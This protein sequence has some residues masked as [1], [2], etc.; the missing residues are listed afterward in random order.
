MSCW[1]NDEGQWNHRHAYLFWF[2]LYCYSYIL[3]YDYV[4]LYTSFI[5][6]NMRTFGIDIDRLFTWKDG[7]DIRL[8]MV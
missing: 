5:H 2:E 6:H 3:V 7:A 1:I 8:D 4:V